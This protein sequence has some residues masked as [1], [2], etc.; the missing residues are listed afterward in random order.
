MQELGIKASRNRVARLMR[1]AAIRS[2]MYKQ[3]RV[4]TTD[5]SHDY[6]VAKNL[7]NRD[8]TATKPGQK[9]VSDI[10]YIPTGEGW[11]YLTTVLDLADRKVIG[12][13]LSD[14]LKAID[15]SVAAWRMALKNRRIKGELLFHSDRG[16]QYACTEFR[17]QLKGLPVVQNMSRK[18]NCWDNAVAESFFKTFKSELVNHTDFP[19]RSVARLATFEY[20]EGWYNRRRK[21]SSLNY[22]TPAQQESYFYT[23][24]M[25]A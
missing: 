20:I 16:V 7:L 2:I 12:W 11:L 23:F 5:S 17:E 14:T 4:Q 1:K 19:T 18:G 21:Q 3:Y 8:L 22:Q 13:A 10:T 9:W 24:P 6:P 15:T 25:A